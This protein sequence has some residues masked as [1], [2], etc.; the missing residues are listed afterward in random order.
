MAKSTKTKKVAVVEFKNEKVL[1]VHTDKRGSIF[2]FV[3][4]KVGHVGM[5]TFAKGV[6]RGNHYHKKSVQYSYII[7]GKI[8]LVISDIDGSNKKEVMLTEGMLTTIPV[9]KV[10]TYTAITKAKMLDI[11]TAS[12]NDNGYEKDTIRI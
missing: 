10:H 3:E 1:P 4:E 12:R 7:E 8:K 5:V 11:T 6:T 9:K 2:D